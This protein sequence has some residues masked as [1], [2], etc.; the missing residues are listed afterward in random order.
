[1]KGFVIIMSKNNKKRKKNDN[2]SKRDV[3]L[4]TSIPFISEY[5]NIS[6]ITG[7]PYIPCVI[8]KSDNTREIITKKYKKSDFLRIVIPD[9][10]QLVD[11]TG[12][13][14][15]PEEMDKGSTSDNCK[16]YNFN[17]YKIKDC[18]SWI[19]MFYKSYNK[20]LQP[21]STVSG[22]VLKDIVTGKYYHLWDNNINIKMTL[23]RKNR[24]N[25]H[26]VFNK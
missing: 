25:I 15:E 14:I 24:N 18:G 7:Y 17:I 22:V 23:V 19:H 10:Y 11:V 12:V 2:N 3:T 8:S 13:N 1:M 16:G 6:G 4:K 5:Y 9:R 26:F 21:F 20:E